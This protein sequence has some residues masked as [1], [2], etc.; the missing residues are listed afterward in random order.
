[1]TTPMKY[2][3][4]VRVA[5]SQGGQEMSVQV[6]AKDVS[7]ALVAATMELDRKGIDRWALVRLAP[8]LP[9]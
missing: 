7:A 2:E 8:L 1:M 4:I 6:A 5:A 9:S 3:V